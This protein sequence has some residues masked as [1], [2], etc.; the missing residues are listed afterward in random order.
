[1]ESTQSKSARP[2]ETT[3]T[4]ESIDDVVLT[5][6]FRPATKQIDD[7]RMGD[8]IFQRDDVATW[9]NCTI[10]LFNGMKH[11]QRSKR[12]YSRRKTISRNKEVASEDNRSVQETTENERKSPLR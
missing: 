10:V 1:M 12:R 8:S 2:S 5:I 11:Q 4:G 7:A 6:N 9:L 3:L